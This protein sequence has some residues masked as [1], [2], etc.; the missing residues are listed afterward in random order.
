MPPP[1]VA[2]LNAVT[3]QLHAIN[4][5]G[6][7]VNGATSSGKVYELFVFVKI[8][9][10]FVAQGRPVRFRNWLANPTAQFIY[11]GA[12]GDISLQVAGGGPHPG[13]LQ[14]QGTAG[15]YWELHN[16]VRFIG[17]SGVFHELDLS[18][19]NQTTGN[20]VRA[21]GAGFNPRLYPNQNAPV[22]ATENKYYNRNLDIGIG[23]EVLGLAAEVYPKFSYLVTNRPP[24]VNVN[25]LF[26]HHSPTGNGTT[27]RGAWNVRDGTGGD[28]LN[29]FCTQ[30]W[31]D[32]GG[33]L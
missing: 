18:L 33:L 22:M 23:R 24:N 2:Q 4:V 31:N 19:I 20:A 7:Q 32:V 28:N 26:A 5:A 17:V 1:T 10:K 13:F 11:R 29:G 8:A 15:R 9:R 25:T 3:N 6:A 12:P 21:S 14:V 27:M 16:S 30:L